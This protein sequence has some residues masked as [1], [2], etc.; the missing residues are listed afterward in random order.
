VLSIDGFG[1]VSWHIVK[2]SLFPAFVDFFLL[3][4]GGG[5]DELHL[6]GHKQWKYASG[7]SKLASYYVAFNPLIEVSAGGP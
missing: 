7:A 1:S 2:V 4:L 6:L 3:F 5:V